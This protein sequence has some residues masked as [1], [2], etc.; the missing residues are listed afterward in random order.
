MAGIAGDDRKVR[1]SRGGRNPAD[2]RP[3]PLHGGA[4]GLLLSRAG[5]LI[6]RAGASPA[7]TGNTQPSEDRSYTL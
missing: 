5:L 6:L 3:E 1:G 4:P 2:P 7:P